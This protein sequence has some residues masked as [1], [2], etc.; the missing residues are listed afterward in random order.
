MRSFARRRAV[1][2]GILALSALISLGGLGLWA[3]YMPA[4]YPGASRSASDTRIRYLPSLV[5]R[6][7]SSYRTGDPF[8]DVYNWYSRRFSLGP[9]SHAQ[10]SCILMGRSFTTLWVIKEQITVTVCA[11]PNGQMMFVDRSSVWNYTR[12]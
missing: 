1:L 5:L 8:P 9:E 4:D 10:G 3:A 2:I 7:T 11:T 6:R 12:R